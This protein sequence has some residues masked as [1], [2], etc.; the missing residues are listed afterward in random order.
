MRKIYKKDALGYIKNKIRDNIQ[1]WRSKT[2]NQAGKEVLI[3][4][5]ITT[6]PSYVMSVFNL[7]K[8]W[9]SEVNAMIGDFWWGLS[10]EGKKYPL[11]KMRHISKVKT[12]GWVRVP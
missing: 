11:E 10:N 1:G 6:I 3:N 8:T 9:C 5:I 4:A 12:Y 2:L 7:R